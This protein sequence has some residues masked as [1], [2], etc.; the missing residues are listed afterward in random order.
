MN[1]LYIVIVVVLFSYS[2]AW[3]HCKNVDCEVSSWT[4]W[5][6]C[7]KSCGNFGQS[8]RTRN[9]NK[10]QEC[11]GRDCPHLS[12]RRGCNRVCCRVDCVYTWE[13]WS[14]CQGACGPNGVQTS[15]LMKAQYE[16]CGGTCN[17]PSIRER[18]RKCD[19]GK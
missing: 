16:N 14:S 10:A 1:K 17:I 18:K 4:S 5:S 2:Q 6:Q 19:T 13:S 15:F 12:E 7:S 11:D 3:F 9:V 8:S